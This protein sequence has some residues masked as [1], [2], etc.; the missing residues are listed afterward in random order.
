MADFACITQKGQTS[1]HK[2]DALDAG[3]KNIAHELLRN[4]SHKDDLNEALSGRIRGIQDK[5]ESALNDG[6][7]MEL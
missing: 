7:Q 1:E 3:L 6:R 4:Q 2:R 5:I